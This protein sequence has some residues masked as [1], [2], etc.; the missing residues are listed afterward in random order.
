MSTTLMILV[1]ITALLGVTVFNGSIL[2]CLISIILGTVYFALL[3]FAKGKLS[4]KL[5]AVTQYGLLILGI[6]FVSLCGIRH[7]KGGLYEYMDKIDKAERL[8]GDE[9]YSAARNAYDNIADMHGQTD[10]ITLAYATIDMYEENYDAVI[11]DVAM[12]ADPKS[13]T[14]YDL[15]LTAMQLKENEDKEKTYKGVSTELG[16]MYI[17]AAATYPDWTYANLMAGCVQLDRDNISSADY[18]LGLA[19]KQDPDSWMNSFQ[20]GVARCRMGDDLSALKLYKQATEDG[21]SDE[22]KKVIAQSLKSIMDRYDVEV[23]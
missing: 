11:E 7:T 12:F 1:M 13:R 18:F 8:L 3:I 10:E 2:F 20:Y 5:F 23:E 9:K 16:D 17:E 4:D 14:A 15:K 19:Y 21:A 6:L 22:A